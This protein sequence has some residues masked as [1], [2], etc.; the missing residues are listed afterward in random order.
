MPDSYAYFRLRAPARD[1]RALLERL[2]EQ[3]LPAWERAGARCWGIWQG[4][5]GVASNELLVMAAAP[6]EHLD[7]SV[8]AA[9]PADAE[10]ADSL[11]LHSTA[12]PL[13]IG[14]L[15]PEGLYVFRFF[16]VRL[17]DCDEI[18]ALSTEAWESFEDTDRYASRPEGL[19]RP[20]G[21]GGDTGRML[22][23]TWYDGFASW[24]AS[25]TPAPEA[26]DNFRRRHALT[27]G[28][29]AYATRLLAPW[30]PQTNQPR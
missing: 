13:S 8:P 25:R 6:G 24:Q 20:H 2:S 14:P 3:T 12:R 29:V 21:D 26:R 18:L 22:L 10:L 5:F 11:A 1:A 28:T 19:F 17:G 7:Q 30:R 15:P 27:A 23:V 9:L 16:D 4:L